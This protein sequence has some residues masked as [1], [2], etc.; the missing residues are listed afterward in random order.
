MSSSN[1]SLSAGKLS[2]NLTNNRLNDAEN[3][4]YCLHSILYQFSQLQY[5]TQYIISITTICT[6]VKFEKYCQS[7]PIGA[8]RTMGGGIE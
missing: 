6:E 1:Y 4:M 2:E 3:I 7:S 5:S 8:G